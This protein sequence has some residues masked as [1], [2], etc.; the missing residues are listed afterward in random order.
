MR[1]HSAGSVIFLLVFFGFGWLNFLVPQ[2][3]FT[4]WM[5]NQVAGLAI[6]STPLL[7]CVCCYFLRNRN[8]KILLAIFLT[9]V[10]PFCLLLQLFVLS[11][12]RGGEQGYN[13][14]FK[15]LERIPISNSTIVAYQCIARDSWT[16]Q[17][18]QEMPLVPGIKLVKR[19]YHGNSGE[20]H[21]EV[22]VELVE[23]PSERLLKIRDWDKEF[24]VPVKRFLYF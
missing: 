24:L 14:R 13:N 21:G 2:I 7:L 17:V 16:L 6:L 9:P 19:L 4:N 3:E 15:Q 20:G 12:I 10:I 22:H 11:D 5:A 18:F 1:Q 8:H 23:T